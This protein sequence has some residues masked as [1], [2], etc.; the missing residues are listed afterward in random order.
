MDNLWIHQG[1]SW[2]P[3]LITMRIQ[4]DKNE[5][6]QA[7]EPFPADKGSVEVCVRNDGWTLAFGSKSMIKVFEQPNHLP[8]K[9]R[10]TD[11]LASRNWCAHDPNQHL[12]FDIVH[13]YYGGLWGCLGN[14]LEMDQLVISCWQAVQPKWVGMYP[15]MSC[16][17]AAINHIRMQARDYY[18]I[19]SKPSTSPNAFSWLSLVIIRIHSQTLTA[20]VH[21]DSSE[22][23]PLQKCH[24]VS[25][26]SVQ[27]HSPPLSQ[28]LHLK[29]VLM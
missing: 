14:V 28:C 29:C 24:N 22:Q 6:N 9:A 8:T 17:H 7:E 25:V 13:C 5:Q 15:K 2:G 16:V 27:S 10:V 19:S 12:I 26:M 3:L 23:D 18:P 4:V 1:T 21:N 11:S 20:I